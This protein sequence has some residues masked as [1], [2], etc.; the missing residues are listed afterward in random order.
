M[1]DPSR[2]TPRTD[3]VLG[4]PASGRLRPAR[5]G[6]G[7]ARPSSRCSRRAGRDGS[8]RTTWS[9]VVLASLPA[10][11]TSLRRGR[12]RHG[13]RRAH[14]PRSRAALR[15]RGRGGHRRVRRH[16]RRARPGHRP[17][18]AA[19]GRRRWPRWPR[20]CRTP[21][22]STWSTTARPRSPSS[23]VPWRS[24]ARWWWRAASW[25]RSVTASGSPSCSS[26]SAAGCARWARPTGC[27]W[28]TTARGRRRRPRSCSRCTPRTSGWRASPP[29][30]PSAS[31]R[32]SASRWWPTS[33]P[34]CWRP[35]PRLPDEPDAASHLRA[36]ADLVTA[37]GDKL[38]GGPQCGL[39]L[40]DAELVQRLRRHPFAR[41]LRVDK[42]TL[43]ALEATLTGPT[44]PVAAALA[45]R[46][47]DLL[48]RAER[49]AA[50]I[51]E[52]ARRGRVDGR[53]RR[54]RSTRRGAAE[55]RRRPARRGWPAHC[56]WDPPVVGH[57][58]DGGCCST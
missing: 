53:R 39:L 11:A 42:L 30:S 7:Q 2:R 17:P 31:S 48:P 57:V 6:A 51:G 27:G 13:R 1:D 28:R 3:T 49:L 12:Q 44:T 33:A 20:R 58:E 24:A 50:S 54:R 35:H 40:G 9:P 14:Q 8:R 38:L 4:R 29:R 21:A 43:A 19:R 22:A 18:R 23:P 10:V 41:A 46:P 34:A 37:S 52:P 25:S 26:R 5:S 32:R 55:R 47:E 36:G 56:G 45:T 15:R 16:R